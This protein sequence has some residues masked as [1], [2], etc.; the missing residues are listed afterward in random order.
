MSFS[1]YRYSPMLFFIVFVGCLMHA[2]VM[3]W[4]CSTV[5]QLE[6]CNIMMF[7]LCG[8]EELFESGLT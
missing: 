1:H 7:F 8:G 5:M 6:M 2:F 4:E 3:I